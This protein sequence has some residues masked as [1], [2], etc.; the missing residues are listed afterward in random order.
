MSRN[1]KLRNRLFDEAI[2]LYY[3]EG[4]TEDAIARRLGVGHSTVNRWVNEYAH[5]QNTDKRSL[6]IKMGGVKSEKALVKDSE[7]EKLLRQLTRKLT[8]ARQQVAMLEELVRTLKGG[9]MEHI[10]QESTEEEL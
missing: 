4:L 7:K 1:S 5:G 6:R 2:G 8:R 3:R 10:L 9:W